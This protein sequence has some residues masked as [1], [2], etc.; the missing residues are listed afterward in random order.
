MFSGGEGV[1]SLM[2]GGR[3]PA[4]GLTCCGGGDKA[5]RKG[6]WMGGSARGFLS[7]EGKSG[8]ARART[9]PSLSPPP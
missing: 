4:R 2:V 7:W 6:R 8:A 5:G 3:A 9:P 1:A